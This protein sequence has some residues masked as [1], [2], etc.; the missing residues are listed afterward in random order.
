MFYIFNNNYASLLFKLEQNKVDFLCLYSILSFDFYLWCNMFTPN[1]FAR[2][3]KRSFPCRLC[4]SSSPMSHAYTRL[5][6]QRGLLHEELPSDGVSCW[7]GG[8]KSI[9]RLR[10]PCAYYHLLN[11]GL[12]DAFLIVLRYFSDTFI[13][14]WYIYWIV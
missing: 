4:S 12:R 6:W 2:K 11:R 5:L 9:V 1:I 3:P 13:I 7:S 14:F 8:I 10:I